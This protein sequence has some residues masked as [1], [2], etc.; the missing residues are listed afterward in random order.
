MKNIISKLKSERNTQIFNEKDTTIIESYDIAKDDLKQNIGLLFMPILFGAFPLL[1]YLVLLVIFFI[2]VESSSLPSPIALI[3][4]I[5]AYFALRF[6]LKMMCRE[7][8]IVLASECLIFYKREFTKTWKEIITIPKNRLSITKSKERALPYN[9]QFNTYKIFYSDGQGS[10][11]ELFGDKYPHE[12]EQ[13]SNII[14]AYINNETIPLSSEIPVAEKESEITDHKLGPK[15]FI[16]NT[17]LTKIDIAAYLLI[18]GGIAETLLLISA[19]INKTGFSGG[20]FFYIIAGVLLIKRKIKTYNQISNGIIFFW[21]LILGALI[22]SFVQPI[23]I[24]FSSGVIP[25]RSKFLLFDPFLLSYC[26]IIPSIMYLIMHPHSRTEMNVPIL[27]KNKFTLFYPLKKTVLIGLGMLVL[28]SLLS[29]PHLL[30]N[31][32]SVIRTKISQSDFIEEKVGAVDSLYIE[33][34]NIFNWRFTTYSKIFGSK[35]SDEMNIG[36]TPQGEFFVQEEED[37]KE[38]LEMSTPIEIIDEAS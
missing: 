1:T 10:P 13:V 8:R 35:K 6:I 2:D 5:I 17:K 37:L 9:K 27:S 38:E 4:V 34:V 18:V 22:S 24:I 31:P 16:G 36:V 21:A 15:T 23:Q 29:G 19:I 11:K 30:K 3:P 20:C 28:S 14:D 25:I 33:G 7:R 12:M 32:Y 26:L